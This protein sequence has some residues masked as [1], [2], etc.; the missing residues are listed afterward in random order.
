MPK[1]L[2]RD[3]KARF[4]FLLKAAKKNPQVITSRG[5][6][7]AAIIDV[8]LFEKLMALLAEAKKPTLQMSMAE[9]KKI[10]ELETEDIEILPRVDRPNQILEDHDEKFAV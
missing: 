10:N 6:P 1:W 9:L 5:E 2:I 8:K 3:A 7:V 4:S